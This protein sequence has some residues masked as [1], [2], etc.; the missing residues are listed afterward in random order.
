MAHFAKI[1][2]ENVVEQVIVIPDAQE[3]RGQD[4]INQELMITGNWLQT[5]YNTRAGKHIN[6]KIP[7]RKNYAGIGYSYDVQRDAFIPP[8]RYPSWILD[9]DTCLWKP[10]FSKPQDGKKYIWDESI[11]NWKEIV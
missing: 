7:F 4:F 6:G 1:N 2:N 10:P 11:T 3:H 5:S 8:K 9:E